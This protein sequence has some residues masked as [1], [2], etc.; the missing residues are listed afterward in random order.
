MV[1]N[2]RSQ[3][4]ISQQDDYRLRF[5][6][7]A[8]L[9][10]K[11]S[12]IDTVHHQHVL[13]CLHELFSSNECG[14]KILELGCGPVIAWQISA[15]PYAS[16]I[17]LAELVESNRDAVRLW[18]SKDTRAHDWTLF[19]RHV[20]QTLEGKGEEEAAKREEQLRRAVKAVIPCDVTKDPPV[21]PDYEGPYDIVMD[22]ASSNVVCE[23]EA[24]YIAFWVRLAKL[25][26]PGG[27][28]VSKIF[29]LEGLPSSTHTY[30]PGGEEKFVAMNV[31]EELLRVSVTKAG[32]TNLKLKMST[33]YDSTYSLI[34]QGATY[35]GYAFLTAVKAS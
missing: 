32:F 5:N 12:K 33:S 17:V 3:K 25:L 24:D 29:V 22:M 23:N 14:G 28:L 4:M 16:E 15:A 20:I 34:Q 18:L 2:L 11:Y 8:Y 31:S 21:P 9:S 1:L 19:F 35:A 26:T 7:N 27:L 10:S 30:L 13:K 6:P